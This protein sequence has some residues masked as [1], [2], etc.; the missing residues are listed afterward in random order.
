[1]KKTWMLG[2]FGSL[3]WSLSMPAFSQTPSTTKT[4]PSYSEALNLLKTGS[5][6][7]DKNSLLSALQVFN[8]CPSP[9]EDVFSCPYRAGQTCLF[10]TRAFDLEKHRDEAEKIL[11]EGIQSAQAAVSLAPDSADTHALLARLYQ[12][13]LMYGDMFTGMDI[14][15]KAG[16]ENEKALS[17]DPQNAQVQL[18]LGVQ[19]VMAPSIGGGDVKK[20]ITTLEKALELDPKMD[21]AYYWLAKAY[22]KQNDR[23]HFEEALQSAVKLN[24]QNPMYP[25]EM[26]GWKP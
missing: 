24:P 22:R 16:A 23:P 11:S 9:H 13:K 17:I 6:S 4:S 26:A 3:V 20:G 19:Y 25:K 1:M 2:L 12:V 18:S 7:L 5:L 10:L 8:D 14:G 21:E 15:P